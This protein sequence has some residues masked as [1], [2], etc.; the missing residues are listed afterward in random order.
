MKINWKKVIG[1]TVAALVVI[2]VFFYNI[3]EQ[4]KLSSGRHIIIALEAKTGPAGALANYSHQ[5]YRMAME[6][7]KKQYGDIIELL[8][9]DTGG[10]SQRAITEFHK[11]KRDNMSLIV[12]LSSPAKAISSLLDGSILT[13]A[14]PVDADVANPERGIYRVYIGANA[15]IP[16]AVK[17]IRNRKLQ[18]AATFTFD[19]DSGLGFRNEFRQAFSQIGGK[20][21]SEQIFTLSQHDG[22]REQVYK[23]VTTN[24]D[25]IFIAGYGSTYLQL[26]RLLKEQGYKGL[27]I[28]T[29]AMTSPE[30]YGQLGNI[31]DGVIVL[32]PDFQKELA[33]R[34]EEKY[35]SEAYYTNIAYG[36]D[37]VMLVANAYLRVKN[38][39]VKTMP[40]AVEK[41]KKYN[42]FS[43]TF[44]V[45]ENGNIINNFAI[46]IMKDGKFVSIEE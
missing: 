43:G 40:E 19:D 45:L 37:S 11:L 16:T 18:T 12:E 38:G 25:V 3:Y 41:N 6:D 5:G 24:P 15:A 27:V 1:W 4:K 10:N 8:E 39:E 13:I 26:F 9:V 28:T 46:Y 22:M 30:M 17:L 35:K 42:G 34:Y 14:S 23:T 20:V 21:V 29:W 2:G 7:I 44:E 33:K 31:T 36:Y 32:T